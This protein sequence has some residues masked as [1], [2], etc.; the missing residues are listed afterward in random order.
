MQILGIIQVR[1]GSSR[2]PGKVMY[3]LNE[4]TILETIVLMLKDSKLLIVNI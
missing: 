3:K 2:L 1:M 4:K